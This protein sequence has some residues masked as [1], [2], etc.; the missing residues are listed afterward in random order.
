GIRTLAHGRGGGQRHR[1]PSKVRA[2][3]AAVHIWLSRRG[4]L[5]NT[6]IVQHRRDAC[7]QDARS[8]LPASGLSPDAFETRRCLP[9]PINSTRLSYFPGPPAQR[10]MSATADIAHISASRDMSFLEDIKYN[11]LH[12]GHDTAQ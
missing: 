2:P 10:V 3:V 5:D 8:S 1:T 9:A 12:E 7:D 6:C 4:S 11:V